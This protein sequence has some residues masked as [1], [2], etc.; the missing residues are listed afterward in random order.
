MINLT[1]FSNSILVTLW[2]NMRTGRITASKFQAASHASPSSSSISLSM[3]ICHPEMNKFKTAATKWGC[4]HE[5]VAQEKYIQ[6]SQ[7]SHDEFNFQE[8]G[9]F[10]STKYP[11][12][13]ASPD[14]LVKCLCCS[15]GICEI[16][17]QYMFQYVNTEI[18]TL[19]IVFI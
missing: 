8:A 19:H 10:L 18:V 6:L 3:S 2:F 14:G 15:N 17:V 5:R 9:L 1:S 12:V 4:D 13:G 7:H 16:K 11:F